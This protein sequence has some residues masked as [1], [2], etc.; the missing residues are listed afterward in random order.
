[1]ISHLYF[2]REQRPYGRRV[3]ESMCVFMS[4]PTDSTEYKNAHLRWTI[5]GRSYS[6][7][8]VGRLVMDAYRKSTYANTPKRLIGSEQLSIFA[9]RISDTLLVI[10]ENGT[11]HITLSMQC[12]CTQMQSQRLA[13]I[14][15]CFLYMLMLVF[16]VSI[17][18]HIHRVRHRRTH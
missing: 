12:V 5:R 7:T 6:Y 17:D 3:E 18:V 10:H 4:C 13:C 16:V 9:G 8:Y 11:T 15:V 1:M 2:G 14:C